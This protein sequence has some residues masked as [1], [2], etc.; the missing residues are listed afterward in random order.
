MD[1]NRDILTIGECECGCGCNE[2]TLHSDHEPDVLLFDEY[3]E[4][5]QSEI[6][7]I[8]EKV[9]ELLE[10]AGT[11]FEECTR[12]EVEQMF[13]GLMYESDSMWLPSMDVDAR[14]NVALNIVVDS[15]GNATFVEED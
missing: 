5:Y 6:I 11:S 10:H 12:K 3:G 2:V 7:R 4:L 14:G 15:E 1:N 8:S 13:D 9:D